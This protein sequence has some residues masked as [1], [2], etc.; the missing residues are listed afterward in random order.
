MA[1]FRFSDLPT[2]LRLRVWEA[3][4]HQE[5]RKRLVIFDEWEGTVTPSKQLISPLL[6]TN[7]ESR[8]VAKT[9]YS[10]TLDV[11]RRNRLSNDE[12]QLA[13]ALC[14]SLTRDIF[15]IGA[16]GESSFSRPEGDRDDLLTFGTKVLYDYH[17]KPLT[18]DD[19]DRVQCT[20]TIYYTSSF[21]SCTRENHCSCYPL[22]SS[23]AQNCKCHNWSPPP[24]SPGSG[25]PWFPPRPSF[26]FSRASARYHLTI[27]AA[28]IDPY[29]IRYQ[30]AQPEFIL[31]TFTR[32]KADR[33]FGLMRDTDAFSCNGK[34]RELADVA[35]SHEDVFDE[36]L[37]P[38]DLEERCREYSRHLYCY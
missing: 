31:D 35:S 1:R 27:T 13:G 5:T 10:L 9:F 12:G 25:P 18:K 34:M 33:P 24:R 3:A 7:R 29:A 6:T 15:V 11:H 22:P 14:L 19:C 26:N 20:L 23:L 30:K 21:L 16:G 17:T 37:F 36:D 8:L 2:E 28:G 4:L 38:P 32:N